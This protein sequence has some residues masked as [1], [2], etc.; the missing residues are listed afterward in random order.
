MLASQEA[1]T[2]F[3]SSKLGFFSGPYAVGENQSTE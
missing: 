2:E 1:K 3:F